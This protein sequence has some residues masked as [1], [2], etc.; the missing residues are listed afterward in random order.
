[1]LIKEYRFPLPFSI[2]KLQNGLRYAIAKMSLNESSNGEGVQFVKDEPYFYETQSKSTTNNNESI[3]DDNQEDISP[4]EKNNDIEKGKNDCDCNHEQ[5]NGQYTYKIYHIS[6]RLPSVI[7]ALLPVSMLQ[8]HEESWNAFPSGV[9]VVT[10]PG[11][12]DRFQIKVQT[13]LSHEKDD[14]N[15]FE[16][17]KS[18]LKKR[19]IEFIDFADKGQT[20]SLENLPEPAEIKLDKAELGPLSPKRWMEDIDHITYCYKLVS[21]EA[22]MWP[23]TGVLERKVHEIEVEVL[24]GLFKNLYAFADEWWDMSEEEVSDFEAKA[25]LKLDQVFEEMNL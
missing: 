14:E 10:I 23:M 16:L 2:D 7:S 22:R 25:K 5:N 15:I 21:I 18:K 6:N 1:M 11:F 8:L 9:T 3:T 17:D 12:G 24:L 19:S 20:N 4:E 13:A